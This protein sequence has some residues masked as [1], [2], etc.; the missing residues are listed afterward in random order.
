MGAG[1]EG[2]RRITVGKVLLPFIKSFF[3]FHLK[4]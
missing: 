2:V 4:V 1:N 3:P